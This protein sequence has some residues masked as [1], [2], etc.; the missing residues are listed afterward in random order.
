MFTGGE[1]QRRWLYHKIKIE[2]PGETIPL[3]DT[4]RYV[5]GLSSER[6][7]YEN[8][9]VN[10]PREPF[11]RISYFDV[12]SGDFLSKYASNFFE[13]K[14]VLIGMAKEE[15]E[16]SVMIPDR[17]VF[18]FE[19]HAAAL[20]TMLQKAYIRRLSEWVTFGATLFCTHLIFMAAVAWRSRRRMVLLLVPIV[21]VLLFGSAWL[22]WNVRWLWLE[23]SYPMLAT[24]ATGIFVWV[25]RS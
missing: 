25:K 8:L 6:Y 12:L 21:C 7:E 2:T 18:R 24:L 15:Y 17:R 23:A 1:F 9:L 5:K 22:L 10:Y 19:I 20:N 4:I 13:D 3:D 11:E 16:S 14:Y